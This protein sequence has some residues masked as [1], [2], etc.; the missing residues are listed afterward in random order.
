MSEP[1][2][3]E[4]TG[5]QDEI[6]WYAIDEWSLRRKLALALAIPMLLAATFGGLRVIQATQDAQNFSRLESR[7]AVVTPAVRMVDSAAAVAIA[8]RGSDTAAAERARTAFDANVTDLRS[9]M[10]TANLTDDQVTALD[11]ALASAQPLR[12]STA[13]TPVE[14]VSGQLTDAV[15]HVTV[16]LRDLAADT[17]DPR[18]TTVRDVLAGQVALTEQ[19]LLTTSA[20]AGTKVDPLALGNAIG[21]EATAIAALSSSLGDTD[22]F[23]DTLASGNELRLSSAQAVAEGTAGLPRAADAGSVYTTLANQINDQVVETMRGRAS[24]S[25]G[26]AIRDSIATIGLLAAAVAL[27]LAVARML[28]EPIKRVRLGALDVANERLPS[29]L[30]RIRAGEEPPPVEP[31]PVHTGEEVGQLARAVDVLHAEAIQL[32]TEQARLRGQ[33]SAMFE[34][35]SRRSTSLINQQLGLIENLER[36]EDDPRRLESLFRLDHLAARIRRNGESLLV[37]AGAAPRSV[38]GQDLPLGDVLRAA[39]SEVQ[40]YQRVRLASS[41]LVIQAGAAPNLVHL[42]AEL[43]DNA[44][45]YSPPDST[46]VVDIARGIDGGTLVEIV[47]DGLGM[48]IDAMEAAND[49]LIDGGEV[50]TDT[51]RRMGLYVVG[52]L[53]IR[54]QVTV[55]IRPNPESTGTIVSVF[56]PASLLSSGRDR[57]VP[58]QVSAPLAAVATAPAAAGVLGR[59]MRVTT[60]SAVPDLPDAARSGEGGLTA[61]RSTASPTALPQVGDTGPLPALTAGAESSSEGNAAAAAPAAAPREASVSGLGGSGLPRRRPGATGAGASGGFGA[62]PATSPATTAATPPVQASSPPPAP[63]ALPP[64]PA[65]ATPAPAAAD[66]TERAQD[67]PAPAHDVPAPVHEAA[68]PA[69][70]SPEPTAEAPTPATQAPA[71]YAAPTFPTAS[72]DFLSIRDLE[73]TPVSGTPIFS[74]VSSSWLSESESGDLPWASSEID[75]GWRAAERATSTEPAEVAPSGLPVRR[76]GSTLVPGQVGTSG[77]GTIARDPEAIRRHLNRHRAGVQ[78]GRREGPT[79]NDSRFGGS[80][81]LDEEKN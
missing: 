24:D 42:F 77:P 58:S 28:L 44:L 15:G 67:V 43:I 9:E 80:T 36:D 29:A 21:E 81:L 7:V 53:A 68:A 70:D 47:D 2:T 59:G 37:L 60:L 12:D 17:S 76:P 61:A 75:E 50:T 31:L 16:V 20:A 65:W 33:V 4:E 13:D 46:V 38:A 54:H 45:S 30:E 27:A 63:A 78:R 6:P 57:D 10:R 64:R 8:G 22:T 51:A 34:T 55:R 35:L 25:R 74:E 52:Q 49:A 19:R 18:L 5:R 41:D 62:P 66:D 40:D 1:L 56:L 69:T 14:T 3:V 39:V 71:A 73:P 26:T 32:A 48:A 72:R 79:Q 23:V 11:R